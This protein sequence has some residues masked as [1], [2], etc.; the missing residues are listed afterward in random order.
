MKIAILQMP[1]GTDKAENLAAACQY[2]H[3]AAL[4]GADIAVLPE[5]FNCPYTAEYFRRFA[6]PAGGESWQVIARQAARDGVCVVAG[7]MPELDE[8]RVYNTSYVF[9]R[10]GRQLARHRKMHLFDIQVDGG[11]VFRESDTFTAGNDVT[12]FMLDG[13]MI[14]LCVCFDFRFP[15][16]ARLMALEGAQIIIVPAAFNMTTGPM[17][18]ELMFRLRAVDNQVFTIGA[19]PARDAGASYVSYANSIVCS[20]WGKVLARADEKP[21]VLCAE[22]DMAEVQAV[23]TQL[24]LLS[25]RRTDVYTM[26]KN[27]PAR[28]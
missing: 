16:L 8:A 26:E 21:C 1:V 24:P 22:L 23:R 15:E 19:A 3:H 6:E 27:H 17:H 5:M 25:A 2:I 20:P 9:D 14:G 11:Q 4:S 10:N 28:G 12:T 7:S 13:V 18:W